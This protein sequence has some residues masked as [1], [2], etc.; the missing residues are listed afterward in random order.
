MQWDSPWGRGF[1]GWH[2]ECSAMSSKY[3]GETFDIHTGGEDNIFPH[4]ESEIAQSEGAS[5]KPF[6]RTWMHVRFLQ[7]DGKKMSKS[8]GNFLT[9]KDLKKRG[10]DPMALRYELISTHYRMQQNFTFESLEGSGSA[11]ARLRTL[12]SRLAEAVRADRKNPSP[13]R[14]LAKVAREAVE[15]FGAA[16]DDDVNMSPA[17][18]HLFDFVR[19]A[20]AQLDRGGVDSADAELALGALHRADSV[21]G[22]LERGAEAAEPDVEE[23]RLLEKRAEARR[24][25]D[26]ETADRIRGELRKRGIV[27]EDT[28][29]GTK[30][31]RVR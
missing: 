4:H 20:N 10:V 12:Q 29:E 1:P 18:G 24:G 5:G 22:V 19:A 17:L 28:R 23:K 25:R 14:E 2:I 7:V 3:L 26:Y 30:W 27:L 21:I 13:N 11:V 6:V 9:L 8:L 15:K 16:L 31:R